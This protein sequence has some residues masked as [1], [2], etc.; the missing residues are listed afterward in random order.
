MKLAHLESMEMHVRGR[1]VPHCTS[2]AY[3]E[4]VPGGIGAIE[5]YDPT[6]TDTS[7][8]FG[9][10]GPGGIGGTILQPL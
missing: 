7:N 9:G 5:A 1:R 10:G 2:G 8:P 3:P 6:Q 4:S